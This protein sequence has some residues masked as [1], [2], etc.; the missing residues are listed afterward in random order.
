MKYFV[1]RVDDYG[2]RHPIQDENGD[3][4]F[5]NNKE[6]ADLERM[7]YQPD[8]KEK[9]MVHETKLMGE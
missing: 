5:F 2:M 8:Y 7:Y 3:I 6:E 4:G 1:I 9:L